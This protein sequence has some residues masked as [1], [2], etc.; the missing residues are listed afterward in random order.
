VD[1]ETWG[2]EIGVVSLGE[3]VT[4][5]MSESVGCGEKEMKE[6]ERAESSIVK[7]GVRELVNGPVER[8]PVQGK[9]IRVRYTQQA[10]QDEFRDV[11]IDVPEDATDEEIT[12]LGEQA[13][14]NVAW[15]DGEWKRLYESDL[16]NRSPGMKD[17]TC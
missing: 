16:I 7:V 12:A 1:L 15:Y 14:E 2:R 11:Y 4:D 5:A 13:I 6:N 3:K 9:T 8:K 17:S 10:H